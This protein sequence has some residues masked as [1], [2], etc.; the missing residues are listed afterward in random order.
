MSEMELED[1]IFKSLGHRIRRD[2]IKTIGMEQLTFSGIKKQIDPIDSPTLSYHLKSLQPLLEQKESN[3]KLSEIGKAAYR[4]LQKTDQSHRIDKG[5]KKFS[6]AYFATVICWICAS[7]I[8]PVVVFSEMD[9]YLRVFLFH[10]II[11]A[12]SLTNYIIV[13]ILRR[14]F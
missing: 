9:F 2:I 4:L 14:S 13:S 10:V 11:N 5:R 12:I 3:Y 8:L 1:D 7:S 6:Y